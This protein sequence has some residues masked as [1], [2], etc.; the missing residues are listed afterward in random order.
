M[1]AGGG[2]AKIVRGITKT[3]LFFVRAGAMAPKH[4]SAGHHQ[5]ACA[6]AGAG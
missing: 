2:M 1:A 3:G 5:M 6:A 4:F